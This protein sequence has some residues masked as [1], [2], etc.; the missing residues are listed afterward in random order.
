MELNA[1]KTKVMVMEKI[2]RGENQDRSNWVSMKTSKANENLSTLII[3]DKC[4]QEIKGEREQ[5]RNHSGD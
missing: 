4:L 3:D 2:A 1:K 5:Q